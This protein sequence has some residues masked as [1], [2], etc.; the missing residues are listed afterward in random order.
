M[1]LTRNGQM[2][3]SI[4]FVGALLLAGIG[5]AQA[6]AV[7]SKYQEQNKQM[8]LYKQELNDAQALIQENTSY[9]AAYECVQIEKNQLQKQVEEL[10]K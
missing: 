8:Q 10:Q 4:A 2:V 3:L 9:K 1:K 7:E 6:K 5:F